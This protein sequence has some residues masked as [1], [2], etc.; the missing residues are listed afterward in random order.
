MRDTVCGNRSDRGTGVGE[1]RMRDTV[2]GDRCMEEFWVPVRCLE[3][4]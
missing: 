4:L 3:T 1:V 2:C